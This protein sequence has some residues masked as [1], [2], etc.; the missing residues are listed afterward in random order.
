[1]PRTIPRQYRLIRLA[2]TLALGGATSVIIA[3][4]CCDRAYWL[5]QGKYISIPAPAGVRANEP[6]AGVELSHYHAFGIDVIDTYY[7]PESSRDE[8]I[9]RKNAIDSRGDALISIEPPLYLVESAAPWLD[10]REFRL[11]HHGVHRA[12]RII[13][14]GWPWAYMQGEYSETNSTKT[15]GLTWDLQGGA[16]TWRRPGWVMLPSAAMFDEAMPLHPMP[17][18]FLAASVAWSI[19][20]IML[21]AAVVGTK[22]WIRN[23]RVRSGC[24][25]ACG[26]AIGVSGQTRCPECGTD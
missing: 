10:E 6:I 1:M 13:A 2:S 14:A 16:V 15:R 8:F 25:R 18:R 3:G 17:L 22:Q 5:E 20:W 9:D 11:L 4:V 7:L 12:G 19:P 23:R 21:Q 24:C 26:Y